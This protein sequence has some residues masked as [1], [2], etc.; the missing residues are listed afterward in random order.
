MMDAEADPCERRRLEDFWLA[1][2]KQYETACDQAEQGYVGQR[3]E[4]A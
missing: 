4:V 1:L 3:L 2:L